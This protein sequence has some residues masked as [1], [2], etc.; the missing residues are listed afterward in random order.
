M[1]LKMKIEKGDQVS[2]PT[3]NGEKETF[4]VSEVSEKEVTLQ[5]YD[6]NDLFS[7][8]MPYD[9]FELSIK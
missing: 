2:V 4:I 9:K 7:F 8:T 1:E 6:F 3:E 5:S